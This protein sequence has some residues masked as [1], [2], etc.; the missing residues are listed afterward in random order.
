MLKNLKEIL[1]TE[2]PYVSRKNHIHTGNF[3]SD[4]TP[5]S[6]QIIRYPAFGRLYQSFSYNMDINISRPL[7][8]YML[9]IS[10]L[11][12]FLVIFGRVYFLS[13]THRAVFNAFK[14]DSYQSN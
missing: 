6:C 5:S 9:H 7:Y 10:K 8:I 11:F 12:L 1:W 3:I 4:G 14:Y 13:D 2:K